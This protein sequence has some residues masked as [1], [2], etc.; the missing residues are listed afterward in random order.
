M[1]AVPRLA[2]VTAVLPS[3]LK[4]RWKD[5]REDTIDL[6]G[7][8]ATGK[9]LLD[10]LTDVRIFAGVELGDYGSSV[11]WPALAEVEIDSFH[12]HLIATEQRPFSA[13]ELKLWQSTLT[14]SNQ[15]SADFFGLALSTWNL[16]RQSGT[17]PQTIGM[18]CRASLRDPVIVSAHYKPRKTGRPA[19]SAGK[20][21]EQPSVPSELRKRPTVARPAKVA[22]KMA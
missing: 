18:L 17:I 2:S 14:L 1:S 21:P 9:P 16:Y 4:V 5:N 7:W 11:R 12:L 19:K 22:A 6:A 20:V 15:E 8:I 10:P 13:E 3:S